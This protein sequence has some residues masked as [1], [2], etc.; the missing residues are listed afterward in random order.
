MTTSTLS[1]LG[2]PT[3]SW[4]VDQAR[5]RVGFAVKQKAGSH[6]A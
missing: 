6:D 3:G 1:R 4:K 2:I 5:T